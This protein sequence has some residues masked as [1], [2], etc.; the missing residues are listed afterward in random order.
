M[1]EV[2]DEIEDFD[3]SVDAFLVSLGINVVIGGS[4]LVGFSMLRNKFA[5]VYSPRL[6]LLDLPTN[7]LPKSFCGWIPKVLKV[8]DEEIFES[9]GIDSLMFLRFFR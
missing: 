2:S 5:T 4:V 3:G 9:V 6:L 7:P 8:T 1:A